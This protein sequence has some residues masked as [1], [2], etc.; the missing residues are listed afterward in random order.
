LTEG[1]IRQKQQNNFQIETKTQQLQDG[2]TFSR[3][4]LSCHHGMMMAKLLQLHLSIMNRS[5]A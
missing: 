1:A 5:S 4:L 3:H 2:D